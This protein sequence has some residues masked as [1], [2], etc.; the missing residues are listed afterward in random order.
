MK[1]TQTRK[2]MGVSPRK[3]IQDGFGKTYGDGFR[4]TYGLFKFNWMDVESRAL[5]IIY[6]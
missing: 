5:T 4:K 6:L 2:I 3:L 1:K